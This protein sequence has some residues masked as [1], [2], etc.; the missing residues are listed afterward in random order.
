MEHRDGV[1]FDVDQARVDRIREDTEY[2]GLRI[3]TTAGNGGARSTDI[4]AD[5]TPSLR[6]FHILF[7]INGLL[8]HTVSR[9]H[10][11][12]VFP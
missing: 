10:G 11:D 6:C 7:S 12:A 4:D 1:R 3:R 5:T 8:E 9:F 2:G